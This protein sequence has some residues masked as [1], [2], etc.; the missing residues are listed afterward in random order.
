[1]AA[2]QLLLLKD[3]DGLGRSGEVVSVKPGYAR[4]FLLPQ[5]LCVIA[6]KFT[7]RMQAKLKEERA[8]QAIVDKSAAEKLAA[9]IHGKEFTIRVK[10]DPEGHLYGSVSALDIAHALKESNF[11]LEKKN[12]ILPH[13]IK[14]LGVQE[15]SLRLKEGV[16]AQIKLNIESDASPL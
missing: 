13:P 4:N 9:E 12:V 1:M 16:L 3:V 6:D 14:T 15:I 7:L 5:K 10:V 8:K 11:D 2:Q